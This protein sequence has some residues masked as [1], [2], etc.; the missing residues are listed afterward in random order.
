MRQINNRQ[1]L[2][3]CLTHY[4]V[5]I[6]AARERRRSEI[7]AR[8]ESPIIIPVKTETRR[9]SLF[10]DDISNIEELFNDFPF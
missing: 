6:H 10:N 9:I 4:V 7:H 1:S 3:S 8:P 5:A 2:T